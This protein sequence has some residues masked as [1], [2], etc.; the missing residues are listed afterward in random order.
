M[1]TTRRRFIIATFIVACAAVAVIITSFATS[2]WVEATLTKPNDAAFSTSLTINYGL[3][4]GHI[5]GKMLSSISAELTMSCLMSE[6]VCLMS[7]QTDDA[8]QEFEL[9]ALLSGI[10]SIHC[11]FLEES[12]NISE[13]SY[14]Q[15]FINAGIW[16]STLLFLALSLL[17][18]VLAAVFAVINSAMNPVEPIVGVF[19]LY[20]WNGIAAGCTL[21]VMILWGAMFAI[22]L[23]DNVAYSQTISGEY[24]SQGQASLGVS[25]W[26]LLIS[27][28]LHIVNL[29]LLGIRQY[30]LSREPP[31]PTVKMDEN[32]D[33]IIFLY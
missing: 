19:G 28:F 1:A 7:C 32:T 9:I 22:T 27:L 5:D 13:D 24:T 17:A 12:T 11:P 26:L 14:D 30:L 33:G 6:N 29:S 2:L 31:T 25:Y 8:T 15:K 3:F 10:E 4:V 16:V 21:I 20:V 23:T 18:A